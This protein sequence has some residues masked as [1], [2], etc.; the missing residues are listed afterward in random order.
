MTEDSV[1]VPHIC[2]I[3]EGSTGSR[4]GKLVLLQKDFTVTRDPSLASGCW[5]RCGALR[6][7]FI[8][9]L[10]STLRTTA[11]L[12]AVFGRH[13]RVRDRG[14]RPSIYDREKTPDP[15]FPVIADTEAASSVLWATS[16]T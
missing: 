12:N 2:F 14:D 16:L 5:L 10:K 8:D 3:T 9:V 13:V 4:D 1:E 15:A 11:R 6:V 7:V